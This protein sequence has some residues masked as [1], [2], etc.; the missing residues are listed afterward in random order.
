MKTLARIALLATVACSA[1]PAAFAQTP[2]AAAVACPT[3]ALMPQGRMQWFGGF[4]PSDDLLTAWCRLQTLPGSVKFNVLFPLT[5]VHKTWE[6]SFQ[7]ANLPPNRIVEIIQ[8]LLPTSVHAPENPDMAFYRVFENV[9][10]AGAKKAP[11]DMDLGFTASHPASREMMLWEPVVLRVKP[12]VMAGQEFTLSVV[13]R[14]N[15]GMFALGQQKKATDVQFLGAKERMNVGNRFTKTCSSLI[16]YCEGLGDVVTF[17]APWIVTGVRLDAEGENMTNTAIT[18]MNHLG[19][20]QNQFLKGRDPLSNFNKSNGSGTMTLTDGI[21]V[22]TVKAT[23][24]PGGT[25]KIAITWEEEGNN[26]DSI[27]AYMRNLAISY[28]TSKKPS[29]NVAPKNPDILNRL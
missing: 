11:D 21:S 12:V 14:P 29:D 26:K 9:V 4:S 28:R 19:L 20:T 25:K 16:P 24:Q 15:L 1:T 6:T 23:G 27:G 22:M 7:G 18:I 10:Q 5:K 17:H 13:L 2:P 8:S 3:P